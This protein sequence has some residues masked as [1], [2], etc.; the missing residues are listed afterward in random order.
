MGRRRPHGCVITSLGSSIPCSPLFLGQHWKQTR[1]FG[2]AVGQSGRRGGR[3][4]PWN[5]NTH[6]SSFTPFLTKPFEEHTPQANFW[7]VLFRRGDGIERDC[8]S[9]LTRG[10]FSSRSVF[11]VA[12]LETG[13]DGNCRGV[14]CSL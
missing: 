14:D 3:F 5:I 8:F 7:R 4:L 6:I 9:D 1:C 11:G 12:L 13:F 10:A 2:I